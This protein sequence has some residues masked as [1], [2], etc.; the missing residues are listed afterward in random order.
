MLAVFASNLAGDWETAPRI[1]TW[2]DKDEAHRVNATWIHALLS[3]ND[4][5][6]KLLLSLCC[7]LGVAWCWHLPVWAK[8]CLGK[9]ELERNTANTVRRT[10]IWFYLC[11]LLPLIQISC[12]FKSYRSSGSIE[13]A[14]EYVSSWAPASSL[15]R[16]CCFKLTRTSFASAAHDS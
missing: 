9:L 4:G 1:F 3:E 10:W 16:S 11:I 7:L 8:D 6:L 2:S 14:T 5:G 12:A 13:T 15:C